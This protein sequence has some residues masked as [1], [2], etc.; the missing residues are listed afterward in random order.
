MRPAPIRQVETQWL[1]LEL[2]SRP[3]E[4]Y[5]EAMRRKTVVLE[6]K[7]R[8]ARPKD[9]AKAERECDR[10]TKVIRSYYALRVEVA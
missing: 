8:W 7:R 3:Y 4:A 1:D 6:D 5:C 10:L 2:I 9:C